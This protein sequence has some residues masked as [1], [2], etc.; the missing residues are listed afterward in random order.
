MEIS[1][2]GVRING[3]IIMML[4]PLMEVPGK[5]EVALIEFAEVACSTASLETVDLHLV[6]SITRAKEDST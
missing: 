3:T 4:L 6:R 2:N 1:R 5:M